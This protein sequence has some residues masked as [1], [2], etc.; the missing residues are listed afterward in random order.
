MSID[1]TSDEEGRI[2][3]LY[4]YDLL[5]A[6]SGTVFESVCQVARSGLGVPIAGIAVIDRESEVPK[7]VAGM[8]EKAIPRS[9]SL[10]ARL[11]AQSGTLAIPNLSTEQGME[12]LAMCAPGTDAVAYAA[13]PLVSPEGYV[14]GAVYV[15]DVHPRTFTQGDLRLLSDLSKLVMEHYSAQ[16][17]ARLDY[18]TSAHTRRAFQAEVEREF[19]RASRYERPAALVFFDIDQFRKINAAFGHGPGDEALQALA[20]RC[21]ETMRQSDIFGR[22]GGE[23]F[24]FLLPEALTY[25]ATQCAER[26]REVVSK[27]RFK[28]SAGVMSV[29]ASFGVAAL[30]PRMTSAAQWFADADVALYGAKQAGGNCVVMATQDRA[31]TKANPLKTEAETDQSKPDKLH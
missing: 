8:S 30:D 10:A 3:A 17:L 5:T 20:N 1:P 18:L 13:A 15:A 14:L 4:R 23:E 25:E 16:Q 19:A 2:A 26:M 24:A 7:A 21:M 31:D 27:L 9:R 6:P 28:T 11:I 12:E 22:I 29:T